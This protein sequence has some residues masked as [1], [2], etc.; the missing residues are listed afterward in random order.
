MAELASPESWC[1]GNGT[2]GSNP[3][4][5]A[6]S[7]GPLTGPRTDTTSHRAFHLC[8]EAPS[9]DP[10]ALRAGNRKS[11][12][13]SRFELFDCERGAVAP[14]SHFP[15]GQAGSEQSSLRLFLVR[16]AVRVCGAEARER[17]PPVGIAR[18]RETSADDAALCQRECRTLLTTRMVRPLTASSRGC[19]PC[20]GPLSPMTLTKILRDRGLAE[21]ATVHGFRSTFRDW[22]AETG[23]PREMQRLCLPTRLGESRARISA[24]ICT[25]IGGC[26]WTSGPRSSPGTRRRLCEC[27]ADQQDS[28]SSVRR[29]LQRQRFIPASTP[30]MAV[31]FRALN[32]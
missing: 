15:P 29:W 4:P 11:L 26:S 22:C 5:S 18:E 10:P 20:C 23:K 32:A 25:R 1:T 19:A 9:A 14:L 30:A 24:L 3:T 13:D 28:L 27:M 31:S 17:R 6:R 16:A 2:V 8:R 21:W 7:R 12:R